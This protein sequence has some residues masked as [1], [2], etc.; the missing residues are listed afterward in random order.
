MERFLPGQKIS[1]IHGKALRKDMPGFGPMVFYVLY[2]PAAALYNGGMR[3]T[4]IEDFKKIPKVLKAI[5]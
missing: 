1:Q 5:K 4:L 3:G 2:H